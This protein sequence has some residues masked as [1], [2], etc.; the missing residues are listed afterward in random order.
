V[1]IYLA[2]FQGMNYLVHLMKNNS[3]IHFSEIAVGALV[4]N[5]Y[6]VFRRLP[7]TWKGAGSASVVEHASLPVGQV[8]VMHVNSLV[9]PA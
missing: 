7:N 9:E 5:K 6:G 1:K 8:V 3:K 2:I 4:R